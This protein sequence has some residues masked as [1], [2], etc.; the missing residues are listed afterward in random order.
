MK[1]VA[2]L[3]IAV[4][5]L[6][7]ITGQARQSTATVFT[8][9]TVLDG[10]GSA[11]PNAVVVVR[12]GRIESIGPGSQAP[13]P[14][15]ARTVDVRGK[16][17]MPGLITAHA[18]ISDVNGLK[19]RGYTDENTLRQLGV[20]ARYGVTSVWSLGGEQAPAFKARETQTSAALDRARIFLSG[21][22][23]TGAT[24]EA[25]RRDGRESR[26]EQAGHHQDPRRR[27]PRRRAEDDAGGLHARSSTRRTSATSASPRTSSISTTPR[28]C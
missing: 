4:M 17:L 27:Q 5:L 13:R 23:I 19:P 10:T 3:G 28:D 2:I 9:A 20:F 14:T 22:I 11:I 12:D 16:F 8:G 7:S 25:A 24:P 15:D 6:G 18:H 26:R 21:D 1:N